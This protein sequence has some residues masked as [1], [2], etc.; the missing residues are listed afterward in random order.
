[1]AIEAVVGLVGGGK[2]N[3]CVR[4]MLGYLCAGH[5][6][7]SNIELVGWSPQGWTSDEVLL[8]CFKNYGVL[9]LPSQFH[10]LDETMLA[11]ARFHKHLVP[12]T[13]ESR[14]LVVLDEATEWMDAL[15]R[16]RLA[17]DD[18]YRQLFTYLRQSRKVY[19]DW[20]FIC[21]SYDAINVRLRNLTSAIIKCT[22]MGQFRVPGL[23]IKFPLDV[24][25]VQQFDRQGKQETG[26]YWFRKDKDLWACYRTI[27]LFS[28]LGL[29][30]GAVGKVALAKGKKQGS[31][32]PLVLSVVAIILAAWA[33]LARPK[34][35][36][37]KASAP[38]PSQATKEAFVMPAAL[39]FLSCQTAQGRFIEYQGGRF[40]VG[41]RLFQEC[42]DKITAINDDF[43]TVGETMIARIEPGAKTLESRNN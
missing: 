24:F 32:L 29:V 2:T 42:Q 35:V 36:Q 37:G 11:G 25:L 10:Y 3:Y 8:Y 4:R 33:L 9:P 6:V 31:A 28:D 5:H 38:E 39:P 23:R 19:H 20:I 40:F 21:Q 34:V 17:Q 18:G 7:A 27:Q 30:V 26:R 43:V 15:D 14:L 22:D 1:M 41:Q 13:K 12:G 16:G